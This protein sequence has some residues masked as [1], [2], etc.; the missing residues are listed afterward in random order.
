MK[1]NLEMILNTLYVAAFN[2]AV[3]YCAFAEPFL[4]VVNSCE[5]ERNWCFTVTDPFRLKPALILG[6]VFV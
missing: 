2:R 5:K 4:F 6:N 1:Y 3:V